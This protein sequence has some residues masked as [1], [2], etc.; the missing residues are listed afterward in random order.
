MADPGSTPAASSLTIVR[1]GET[2]WSQDGRHTSVTDLALLGQGREHARH[3]RSRLEGG[4]F[5]AVW[6]SPRLR[7]RETAA[8]AGF[9]GRLELHDDLVEWD[10]GDYEGLTTAQIRD[11]DPGW[12]LWRDGCPG[13]ESPGV[14]AAR[15]DRAIARAETAGGP[16][17]LFAHGHFLR[18]LAVRWLDAPFELGARLLLSPGSV[19]HLGRDRSARVL[20]R[21]NV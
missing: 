19:S 13:G 6:S 18:M 4:D 16:V 5:V 12:Q 15:A 1:H 10:Y 7:A 17:L 2:E 3:L 9:D 11:R 14:V 8:L 21:W 20:E